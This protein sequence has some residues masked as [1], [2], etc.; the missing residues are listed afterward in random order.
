MIGGRIYT[1]NSNGYI[2]QEKATAVLIKNRDTD[3]LIR[4]LAK[5]TGE[6]ITH[7][8]KTAARERL[9]RL[10]PACSGSIDHER[11]EAILAKIRSYPRAKARLTDDEIIGYDENGVPS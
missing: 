2:A 7:A 8:V 1:V 10:P 6:T 4:E 11:L 5:R 9:E 3:E